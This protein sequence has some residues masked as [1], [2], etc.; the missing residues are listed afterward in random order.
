M[1]QFSQWKT[2]GYAAAIFVVGGISG[3][4]LGVYQTK[5][6]LFAPSREDEIALHLRN[7][8]QTGLGLT[9]DQVA[10]INPITDSA[11]SEIRSI[12]T[13]TMQRVNKV[14]ED[15]YAKVSAIL[16]P[17]QRTK[18]DQ[19]QKERHDMMQPHWQESGGG[20]RH[21]GDGAGSPDHDGPSHDGPSHDAPSPSPV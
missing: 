7:R 15:S 16:T 8:L 18:L 19:M 4:A 5:S 10:K 1:S 6:H 13:E 3:G 21:P 11:A 12:R 17:D 9:P 20:R 14:F 2:M